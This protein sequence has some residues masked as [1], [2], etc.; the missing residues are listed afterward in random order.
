MPKVD[1]NKMLPTRRTPG[2]SRCGR[3]RR[4]EP[5]ADHAQREHHPGARRQVSGSRRSVRRDEG[6]A[7]RLLPHRG[8]DPRRGDRVGRPLPGRGLRCDRGSPVVA[9]DGLTEAR[10]E[11]ERVARDGYGRLLAFLASR[12]HDVAVA[13]DALADA[14]AAALA[15]WPVTGVPRVPEAWLLVTA[16]RRMSD[17]ARRRRVRER[18]Q[19]RLLHAAEEATARCAEDD[20][21]PDERLQ[22][23]F[24]CAHPA[25]DPATPRAAHPP[26]RAGPRRRPRRHLR[27]VW[28][29]T[30]HRRGGSPRPRHHAPAPR[31]ARDAG[32]ARPHVASPGAQ[33][34]A[35]GI[36][37]HVHPADGAGPEPVERDA[38]QRGRAP[39][40]VRQRARTPGPI[41]ARSGRAVG[42]RGT[43]P[44]GP[45][46]LAR[47]PRPLRR[48]AARDRIDRGGDQPCGRARRGR[49]ARPRARRARPDRR[50]PA[51][52]R[53]PAVLGRTRRH[54]GP[55]RPVGCRAGLRA[56]A[57]ADHRRRSPALP[58]RAPRGGADFH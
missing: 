19:D 10:V 50:R 26:D 55:A 17:E 14:F 44:D 52:R 28:R 11:A 7:R 58:R 30:S 16:R 41:P 21:I 31:R 5:P 3:A 29:G 39:P 9:D 24:A 49:R 4:R 22:L 18:D 57:R 12:T 47:D 51:P 33:P 53:L 20:A 40:A 25:I 36:G 15:H 8:R 38:D 42:A 54:P 34:G 56:R 23:M 13:E 37:R 27:R 48:A 35:T 32:T 1:V 45:H 2:P 6:A 43:A 46:R